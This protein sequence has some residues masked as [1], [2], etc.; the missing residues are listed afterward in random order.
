[1][2]F[3]HSKRSQ[4][5]NRFS[6]NSRPIFPNSSVKNS[7]CTSHQLCCLIHF[8]AP[9]NIKRKRKNPI[10]RVPQYVKIIPYVEPSSFR[11]TIISL[12]VIDWIISVHS[13][14]K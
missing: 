11:R 8:E 5:N 7:S 3:P 10:R 13:E 4:T 1:F 2:D 12:F 6:V 14:A 9:P